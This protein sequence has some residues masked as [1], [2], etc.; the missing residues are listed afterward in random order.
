MTTTRYLIKRCPSALF[1]VLLAWCCITGTA[2]TDEEEAGDNTKPA[3]TAAEE[4]QED[5]DV[6]KDNFSLPLD[7]LFCSLV[8]IKCT[9]D[10]GDLTGNGFVANMDGRTYIFTTQH[11]I[12][13]TD[14][15]KFTTVSGERLTPTGVELAMTRDI[16][17]LPIADRPDALT[18]NDATLMHMPIAVFGS[19]EDD[20]AKALYGKVTGVGGELIEVSAEFEADHS[21]SPLLNDAMEVIGIASYV[22]SPQPNR[23]SENTRFEHQTRRFCYRLINVKWAPVR[24][25]QYNEKYGKTYRE[26]VVLAECVFNVVGGLYEAPFD[27]VS[28]TSADSELDRWSSEHNR[29]ISKDGSQRRSDMGRST[30]ALSKYCKRKAGALEIKLSNRDMTGFLRD[31]LESYK[32]SFEYAADAVDF[33]NSKLPAM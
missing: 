11:L 12:M 6:D 5:A 26:T 24:W 25:K 19:N 31:E 15:I 9:S 30:K 8:S 28:V 22:R 27:R 21:G 17:R 23:T 1:I 20:V 32:Y 2:W 3:E 29:A 14:T 7:D 13:G 33:I 4:Q 10:F 18:I 16:A